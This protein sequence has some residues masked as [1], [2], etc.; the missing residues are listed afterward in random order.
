MR[1]EQCPAKVEWCWPGISLEDTAAM[2]GG[3]EVQAWLWGE[4]AGHAK[5]VEKVIKVRAA[6]HTHVLAC[7]HEL[8][9][10]RVRE[11][12]GATAE[13]AAGF[14]YR[15]AKSTRSERRGTR[16]SGQAPTNY[17]DT[18]HNDLLSQSQKFLNG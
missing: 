5:G 12:T 3:H 13:P 9:A 17:R 14:E 4:Q 8:A 6:P 10:F 7:I 18:I 2:V 11:R 15:D 1:P 16:Q